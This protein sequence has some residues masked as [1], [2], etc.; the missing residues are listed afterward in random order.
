MADTADKPA[1]SEPVRII[2]PDDFPV[3]WD[4]PEEAG[5]LWSW[6]NFHAP[7][8]PSP[9]SR[10]IG[11]ITHVGAE[12]VY[13][14]FGLEP[15]STHRKF[16]NGYPYAV[17][18]QESG[19]ERDEF[20]RKATDAIASTEVRWVEEFLPELEADLAE[21]KAVDLA[22]LTDDGVWITFNSS[23]RNRF[24]IGKS[25]SWSC[26]HFLRQGNACRKLTKS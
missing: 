11:E 13:R 17:V 20:K 19:G 15:G 3:E 12:A 26:S 6:N 2:P 22:T 4:S 21:M 18:E 5:L 10:T 8:P 16:I 14:A 9:M 1:Q 23:F 25:I 7:V 24:G